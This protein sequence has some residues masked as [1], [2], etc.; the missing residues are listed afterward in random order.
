MPSDDR[1]LANNKQ[2]G[3]NPQPSSFQNESLIE[4]YFKE[5]YVYYSKYD[6]LISRVMLKIFKKSDYSSVAIN[7]EVD[8][9]FKEE[10][11]KLKRKYPKTFKDEDFFLDKVEES[12]SGSIDSITQRSLRNLMNEISKENI[13]L[14]EAVKKLARVEYFSKHLEGLEERVKTG[15]IKEGETMEEETPSSLSSAP[16]VA[17]GALSHIL[18]PHRVPRPSAPHIPSHTSAPTQ[19]SASINIPFPTPP[20]PSS[21]HGLGKSS[22][23]NQGGGTPARSG[24]PGSFSSKTTTPSA[25]AR[26]APASSDFSTP[27]VPAR[28]TPSTHTPQAS[29]TIPETT[30]ANTP[31]DQHKGSSPASQQTSPQASIESA[32]TSAPIHSAPSAQPEDYPAGTSQ[33]QGAAEPMTDHQGEEKPGRQAQ[34]DPIVSQNMSGDVPQETPNTPPN[35]AGQAPATSASPQ[36]AGGPAPVAGSDKIP[37]QPQGLEKPTAD[38]AP[39]EGGGGIDKKDLF[40]QIKKKAEESIINAF[41]EGSLE[42]NAEGGIGTGNNKTSPT[43]ERQKEMNRIKNDARNKAGAD[44]MLRS[45]MRYGTDELHDKNLSE[46]E[47]KDLKTEALKEEA[48]AEAQK[49]IDKALKNIHNKRARM[50]LGLAG[51]HMDKVASVISSKLA[52]EA[53][54]GGFHA[55][56][57]I[58]ITYL[59][60]FAKDFI[61]F[62]GVGSIVGILTGIIAGL[63]IAMF[64]V[65][66]SG[67]WKGGFITRRLIKRILVKIGAAAIV[68][69]LIGINL[70]PTFIIMNLWS[71]YDWTKSIKE[72]K[73]R[74]VAFDHEWKNHKRISNAN[75]SNYG[76]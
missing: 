52:A 33:S 75:I 6:D 67:G 48:N 70:I 38:D 19:A 35:L 58:G 45:P 24:S 18:T 30:P 36:T 28:T 4:K 20:T 31:H 65:Q 10:A 8:R 5:G 16:Y 41:D 39:E 26:T 37:S 42:R 13:A 61:D 9:A 56:I 72:S 51:I 69:S 2:G 32:P 62:T 71:H 64:W 49:E 34:Q 22:S 57:P 21:S 11:D 54:R 59:V 14:A 23:G 50:A 27:S 1:K 12:S 25:P 44:Q 60:A 29:Q 76:A 73:D 3:A 66:V 17:L 68:E 15:E 55:I 74:K 7:A 40:K 43:G 47:N 53:N 63:I 46:Q